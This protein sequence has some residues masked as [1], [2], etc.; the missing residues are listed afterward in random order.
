M[1]VGEG[2]GRVTSVVEPTAALW[3]APVPF[4]QGIW[5]QL[6]AGVLTVT[7]KVVVTADCSELYVTEATVIVIVCAACSSVFVL[8]GAAV[9]V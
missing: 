9:I 3:V 8:V 6:Q 4:Y 2:K 5:A 7:V 1:P